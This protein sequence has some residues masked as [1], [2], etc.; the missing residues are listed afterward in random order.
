MQC[1]GDVGMTAANVT[2]VALMCSCDVDCCEEFM[3][4][5]GRSYKRE[6]AL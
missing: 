2:E 4:C 1:E 5:Q 3:F 6:C